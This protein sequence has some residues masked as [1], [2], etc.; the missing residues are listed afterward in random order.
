MRTIGIVLFMY[1]T[2]RNLRESYAEDDLITYGWLSIL[3]LLIGSRIA[4]GVLHWGVWNDRWLNWLLF[5]EKPGSSL[6]FGYL[7]MILVSWW[8]AGTRGWRVWSFLED[9]T[10]NLLLMLGLIIANDNLASWMDVK[11]WLI[12]VVLIVGGLIG[13]LLSGRYRSFV[14]Y[15]SGKKGFVFLVVNMV[16]WLLL[17][18]LNRNYWSLGLSLI[19]LLGLV[20]LGDVFTWLK[21]SSRRK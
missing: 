20:I 6:V 13:W 7:V 12:V 4:F 18:G 1:L 9:I 5:W 14:W 17:A 10:F 3:A 19:S 2:W 11:K 15:R 21:V 8:W 16:V